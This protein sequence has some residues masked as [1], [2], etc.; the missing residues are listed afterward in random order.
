MADGASRPD[1][2]AALGRGVCRLLADHGLAPLL[3]M[4]LPNGRRADV[5]ALDARGAI[6]IVETKSGLADF[7]ADTK[8]PEYLD[9]CD[10]F[11]FAAPPEFPFTVIDPLCGIIAADNFGGEILRHGPIRGLAPARRKAVTLAFAR[12]AA[13]RALK[14]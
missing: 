2:T 10:A 14:T 13:A 4:P 9:Y 5:M 3:E 7:I 12:Q 6:W 11:Y 8:W 1:I